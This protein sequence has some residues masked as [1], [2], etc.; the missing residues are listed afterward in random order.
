[1][2]INEDGS[3]QGE[4]F[5]KT[6]GIEYPHPNSGKETYRQYRDRVSEL[7]KAGFHLGDLIWSD[8]DIYCKGSGMYDMTGNGD[9]FDSDQ[10]I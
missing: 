7:V 9:I 3:V 8:Y 10:I 5:T 1:M 6:P 4:L 2:Q